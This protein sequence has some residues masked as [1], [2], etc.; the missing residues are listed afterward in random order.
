MKIFWI[1]S[2]RKKD[3]MK[4]TKINSVLE[5]NDLYKSILNLVNR[6]TFFD[7]NES[8]YYVPDY[9]EREIRM[10]YKNIQRVSVLRWNI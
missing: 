3:L 5:K 10:K 2:S 1:Y 9:I 8:S 4:S 6:D 7:V